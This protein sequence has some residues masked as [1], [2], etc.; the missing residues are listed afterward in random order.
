[1]NRKG[2]GILGN[3]WLHIAGCSGGSFRAHGWQILQQ[4]LPNHSSLYQPRLD[5]GGAGRVDGIES[6]LGTSRAV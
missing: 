6:W 5:T 1:V 3:P 4:T 2:T